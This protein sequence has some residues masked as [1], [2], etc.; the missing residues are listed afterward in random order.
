MVKERNKRDFS[1]LKKQYPLDSDLARSGLKGSYFKKMYRL[2]EKNKL[3]ASDIVIDF[4]WYIYE[5]FNS[6]SL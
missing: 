4:M 2:R 1:V 6:C 5:T 3:N